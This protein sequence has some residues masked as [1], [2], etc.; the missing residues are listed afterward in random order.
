M[1][2]EPIIREMEFV[3]RVTRIV[4]LLTWTALLAVALLVFCIL[5]VFVAVPAL[6]SDA[7]T[8]AREVGVAGQEAASAIAKD[9]S[10]ALSVP[11]YAGTAL[12]Q[13]GLSPDEIADAARQTLADPVEP[14]GAAGRALIEGAVSRPASP[15]SSQEP[16]V[17]RSEAIISDPGASSLGADGLASGSMSDCTADL[18]DAG[19]GGVCGSVAYC[20]G[21]GCESVGTRANTGFARS[22]ARLNMALEMGGEEF[23]RDNLRLFTGERRA[24]RIKLAGLANCCNDSGFLIGILGCSEEEHLLAQERHVGNTHYLGERCAENIFGI[25]FKNE[26][27]WCVFGSK[28]GRILHEGARP[29]LGMNWADC[30]GFTVAEIERIDFERVDLSEFTDNLMGGDKAPGVSLPDASDVGA[31]MSARIRDY[32]ERNQ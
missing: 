16:A 19:N 8:I 32:Y 12:P 2:M 25:C 9:P 23:D 26:R 17:R 13:T 18:D 28:L 24:C 7:Q 1:N 14:G 20:V 27:A 11:G 29:Q 15:V 3:E 31:A 4:R 30:R 6:A 10:N 21:A 5:A 22:A